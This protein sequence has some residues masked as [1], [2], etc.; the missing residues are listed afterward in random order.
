MNKIC[1]KLKINFD[2]E[3]C[4]GIK[5]NQLLIDHLN[6][7]LAT[8]C[9]HKNNHIHNEMASM[10]L[11]DMNILLGMHTTWREQKT[12]VIRSL[13]ERNILGPE[14]AKRL[15]HKNVGIKGFRLDEDCTIRKT[16]LQGTD[17]KFI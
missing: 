2:S 9:S 4:L 7:K 3:I 10:Q 1:K 8:P 14:E 16:Y 15:L 5:P 12:L 11:F 17:S 13:V 6:Y